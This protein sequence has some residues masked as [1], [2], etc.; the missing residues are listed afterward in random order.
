MQTYATHVLG[1]NYLTNS[2]LCKWV[3]HRFM[4]ECLTGIKCL[5]LELRSKDQVKFPYRFLVNGQMLYS[6]GGMEAQ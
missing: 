4:P 1:L 5:P 6:Y 2:L 3:P